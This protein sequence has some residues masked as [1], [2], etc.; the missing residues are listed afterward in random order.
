M[1]DPVCY[2]DEEKG[3][4]RGKDGKCVKICKCNWKYKYSNKQHPTTSIN[5]KDQPFFS[6]LISHHIEKNVLCGDL[7]IESFLR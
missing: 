5:T 7:W 4:E 6:F 1:L 3:Y 2:C